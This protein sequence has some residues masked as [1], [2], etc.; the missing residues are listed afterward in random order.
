MRKQ[1]CHNSGALHP[2]LADRAS[3]RDHVLRLAALE[4]EQP[5]GILPQLVLRSWPQGL[6]VVDSLSGEDCDVV[7]VDLD[8]LEAVLNAL[9]KWTVTAILW[10]Y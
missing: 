5:D 2:A 4:V 1:S 3:D 7:G 8:S 10:L 6:R 9:R